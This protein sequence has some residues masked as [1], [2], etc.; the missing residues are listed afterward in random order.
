MTNSCLN[1]FEAILV[2]SCYTLNPDSSQSSGSTSPSFSWAFINKISFL[3][4]L[5][6]VTVATHLTWA[7]A[8]LVLISLRKVP[9]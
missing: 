7:L 8:D 1:D 9:H 6:I 4:H 3:G 2:P 5:V